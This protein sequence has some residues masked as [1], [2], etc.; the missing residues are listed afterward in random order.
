G[1][2]PDSARMR[3]DCRMDATAGGPRLLIEHVERIDSTNS[4][5][6]RREPLLPS[7]AAAA[8]VWLVAAEQ[9][10]GRGRRQRNWLSTRHGSLTA[11]LGYEIAEP[12]NLGA[13]SLAAGVA[14]AEAL[15]GFGIEAR[16]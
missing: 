13:L 3:L 14:V 10:S 1:R 16:L 12:R 2:G 15:V 8:G 9:T 11:S 7:G 6:L 5:L 4:E